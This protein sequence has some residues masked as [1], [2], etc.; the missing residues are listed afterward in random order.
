MLPTLKR[1]DTQWHIWRTLYLTNTEAK[2]SLSVRPIW[3][4]LPAAIFKKRR[5][6]YSSWCELKSTRGENHFITPS[7]MVS[8]WEIEL[9]AARLCVSV[10]RFSEFI[11]DKWLPL[12][13]RSF[14]LN[15]LKQIDHRVSPLRLHSYRLCGY[16]PNA[17]GQCSALIV[18]CGTLCKIHVFCAFSVYGLN[19]NSV[20]VHLMANTWTTTSRHRSFL[21]F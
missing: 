20:S 15:W 7:M 19:R 21:Y 8:L 1:R 4:D 13:G 5:G 2:G 12:L 11:E 3:L 14:E 6:Q 17:Q 10:S 18:S 9:T 16:A